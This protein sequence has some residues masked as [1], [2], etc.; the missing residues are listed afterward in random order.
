METKPKE[1]YSL[2]EI[3]FEIDGPA[4]EVSPGIISGGYKVMKVKKMYRFEESLRRLQ[5][6]GYERHLRPDEFYTFLLKTVYER[7]NTPDQSK[8]I[9]DMKL[10]VD[11]STEKQPYYGEFLSAAMELEG[12]TLTLYLDPQGLKYNPDSEP[13]YIKGPLFSYNDIKKFKV[14]QQEE[15]GIRLNQVEGLIKYLFDDIHDFRE[16][17]AFCHCKGSSPLAETRENL[18]E[19]RI[20]PA[21]SIAPIGFGTGYGKEK[22]FFDMVAYPERASRGIRKRR[23][24]KAKAVP[25]TWPNW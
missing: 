3:E 22:G 19:M 1:S 21:K 23:R 8:V 7:R 18:Q 24:E 14:K 2:D 5:S 12:T 20:F 11:I 25:D 4:E 9:E 17:P 15:N 13:F 16:L 10:P 6:N